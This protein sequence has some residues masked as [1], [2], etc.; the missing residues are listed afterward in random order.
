MNPAAHEFGLLF[1]Q[2]V[3]LLGRHL[4]AFLQMSNNAIQH[5]GFAVAEGHDCVLKRLTTPQQR[6]A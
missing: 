4:V 2:T 5:A 6:L 1:G 3:I